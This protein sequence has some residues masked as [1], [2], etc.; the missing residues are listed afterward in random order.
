MLPK[1]CCVNR[2]ERAG[3]PYHILLRTVSAVFFL[4][5][6]APTLLAILWSTQVLSTIQPVSSYHPYY[7]LMKVA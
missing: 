1:S 3:I 7:V 4:V 6:I 5:A 2:K